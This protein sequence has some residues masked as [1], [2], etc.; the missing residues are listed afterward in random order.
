[1]SLCGGLANCMQGV[2]FSF[3]FWFLV[4]CPPIRDS[5]LER[6]WSII[7]RPHHHHH[8]NLTRYNQ[9]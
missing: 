5:F 1:M 4:V 6:F 7:I 9:F 3:G 2:E 8:K